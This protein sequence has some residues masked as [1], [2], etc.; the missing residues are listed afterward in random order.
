VKLLDKFA[1]SERQS[2]RRAV[3]AQ[4]AVAKVPS[5][6]LSSATIAA[7]I[8]LFPPGTKRLKRILTDHSLIMA[9]LKKPN[10]L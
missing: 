5:T 8:T 2:R 10:G 4:K 6:R 3:Q 9:T 7:K 1:L